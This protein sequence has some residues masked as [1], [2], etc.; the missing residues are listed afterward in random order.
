MLACSA[1]HIVDYQFKLPGNLI[2]Y[3]AIDVLGNPGLLCLL[4]SRIFLNLK[5][6]AETRVNGGVYSRGGTIEDPIFAEPAELDS[7]VC[8]LI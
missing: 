1:V 4:G 3:T 6:A 5:E 2:G 8:C 7:D